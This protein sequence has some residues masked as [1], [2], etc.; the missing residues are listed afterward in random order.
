MT[1]QRKNLKS[2]IETLGDC[3]AEPDLEKEAIISN[4]HHI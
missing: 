3:C 1:A 4:K 2:D